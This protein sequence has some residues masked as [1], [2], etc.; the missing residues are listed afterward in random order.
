VLLLATAVLAGCQTQPKPNVFYCGGAGGGGLMNWGR[1]IKDGLRRGGY[2]GD[3]TNFR[4]QSGWGVIADQQMDIRKKRKKAEELALEMEEHLDRN[5]GQP[6]YLVGLSAGSSIAIYTLEELPERVPVSAVVLLGPS[7]SSKYDLTAALRRVRG[8][9]YIYTS[10]RDAVLKMFVP[11]TGTADRVYAGNDVAGLVG[12]QIPESA[13]RETMWQY[14]D[15]LVNVPW[16]KERR[17]AGDRGGHTD[18]TRAK[19]VEQHVVPRVL[20]DRTP[21]PV[22]PE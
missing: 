15:K 17:A 8:K 19:F 12:F 11:M 3:Y 21:R 2:K 10:D 20:E 22:P 1:S 18:T 14:E 16:D 7:M 9:M 4:W 6:L 5:P 13:G